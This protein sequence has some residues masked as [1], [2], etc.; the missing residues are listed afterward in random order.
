MDLIPNKLYLVGNCERPSLNFDK[1]D[2]NDA[3]LS[4]VPLVTRNH[5]WTGSYSLICTINFPVR[6]SINKIKMYKKMV[7]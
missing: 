4:A 6:C 1:N 7:R 2:K 3:M 5:C